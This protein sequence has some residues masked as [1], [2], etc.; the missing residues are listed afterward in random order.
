MTES[1]SP[2]IM[3]VDDEKDVLFVVAKTLEKE[4]YSVHSFTDSEVALRH[5]EGGCLDC[6]L[7]VS[8][9]RMPKLNGFQLVRR[10]KD[11]RPDMQVIMM[12]AFEVN[13]VEFR[14]VFPTLPVNE[15]LRKPF[16]GS[17]LLEYVK[18]IMPIEIKESPRQ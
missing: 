5:I 17:V 9:I 13:M 16:V 6:K 12:T 10:I 18:R 1:R 3:V 11:L 8:D 2:A 4:G 15:V 7:L 14:L